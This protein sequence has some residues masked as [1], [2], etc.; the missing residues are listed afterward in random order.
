[1][2]LEELRF[3]LYG[4]GVR[5][6][7]ALLDLDLT[8]FW[9]DDEEPP[10]EDDPQEPVVMP[11]HFYDLDHP[12]AAKGRAYMEGRG[13]PADVCR[14]TASATAPSSGASSSRW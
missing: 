9:G 5:S 8:D 14:S 3:K 12:F 6:D 7:G 2:S 4:I 1:M 13:L 10:D 11:Y